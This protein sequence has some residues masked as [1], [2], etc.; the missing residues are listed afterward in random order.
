MQL[1]QPRLQSVNTKAMG[2]K[3]LLQQNVFNLAK[4]TK[5]IITS[6]SISL[7]HHKPMKLLRLISVV[8]GF[9]K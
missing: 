9:V 5:C 2:L 7:Q 8:R 1:H 6:I 3:V 4:Y